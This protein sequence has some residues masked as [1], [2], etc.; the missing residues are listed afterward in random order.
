MN[1]ILKKIMA[2]LHEHTGDIPVDAGDEIETLVNEA[3][4]RINPPTKKD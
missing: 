2:I 3:L 4:A 1:E